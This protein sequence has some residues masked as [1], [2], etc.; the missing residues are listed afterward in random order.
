MNY[1]TMSAFGDE[2]VKISKVKPTVLGRV[3]R[4]IDQG[5]RKGFIFDKAH[6]KKVRAEHGSVVPYVMGA[7][8]KA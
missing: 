6:I 3:K 2:L 5:K 8:S 1:E 4:F 7:P